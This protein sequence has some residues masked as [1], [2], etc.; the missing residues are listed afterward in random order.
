MPNEVVAGLLISIDGNTVKLRTE[1]DKAAA[2]TRATAQTMKTSMN[3]ARGTVM[4]L[5][6]EIG[7]HLPR[8]VQRFIASLPGAAP[9]LASAFAATAVIAIGVAIFEAGKKVYEY[10]EKLKE[11]ARKHTDTWRSIA[12]PMRMANDELQVANDKLENLNAKLQGK[13]QN[14]LKLAIDEAIESADKLND[15]L[16]ADIKKIAEALKGEEIGSLWSFLTGAAGTGDLTERSRGLQTTL[17]GAKTP[18][19]YQA[20]IQK[21][22]DWIKTEL[23]KTFKTEFTN[24]ELGMMPLLAKQGLPMPTGTQT[25]LP[26]QGG[27]RDLLTD[28]LAQLSQMG[29]FVDLTQTNTTD[30]MLNK[31]LQGRGK[32]GKAEDPNADARNDFVRQT[33]E[34][35]K[36]LRAEAERDS[37][38]FA[39]TWE[40]ETKRLREQQEDLTQTGERWKA[41]SAEVLRGS[42]IQQKLSTAY[43]VQ[44]I[45]FRQEFGA[46]TARAAKLA[47]VRE[48][49]RGLRQE[50][51]NIGAEKT[52][53]SGDESLTPVERATRLA[54]L[55]NQ[56]AQLGGEMQL[57]Q[58]ELTFLQKENSLLGQ[59]HE[60]LGNVANQ[61]TNVGEI[62]SRT[63]V[64]VMNT[65]NDELIKMMTTQYHKGD[66]KNA[67]ATIF[68]GVAKDSLQAGEGSI[69]KAFGIG[70]KP[71]SSR[72]HPMWTRDAGASFSGGGDSGLFSSTGADSA[73]DSGGFWAGLKSFFGGGRAG[74]GLMQPGRFYLTGERGPEL[75]HVGATSSIA[76]NRDTQRLFSGGGGGSTNHVEQHFHFDVSGVSIS[77]VD[78]RVQRSIR[79][80]GPSIAAAAVNAIYDMQARRPA[81]GGL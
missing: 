1:L 63:A 53:V 44:Q 50:S 3:D 30:N 43:A 51:E 55:N 52:R 26:G 79:Q 45:R 65:V 6:E 54:G 11:A 74:G 35:D 23:P 39:K 7:V 78:R 12:E 31:Q 76:S 22:I 17:E 66:W 19:D 13:P 33:L 41:Y 67:G 27:R 37:G 36:I 61:W 58:S 69:M 25:T 28:Y 9:L 29:H 4:V 59:M 47:E 64:N 24:A 73:A 72:S 62:M 57:K 8:H 2:T 18:A 77:D 68:K 20:A 21:E 15:H 14:G 42:E 32:Q 46:L 75:M 40:D 60:T 16:S 48:E 49:L 34:N 81:R 71:G 80:E 70:A 56:S 38:I 10:G 5:G